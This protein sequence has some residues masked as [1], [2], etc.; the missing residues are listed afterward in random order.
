MLTLKK[1]R[2]KKEEKEKGKGE[3]TKARAGEGLSGQHCLLLHR[4]Q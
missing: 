3:R 1:I 4:T 2:K